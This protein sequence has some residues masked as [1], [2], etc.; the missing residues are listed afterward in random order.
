MLMLQT[1]RDKEFFQQSSRIT[2]QLRV[3]GRDGRAR[4]TAVE[5]FRPG[6]FSFVLA[7]EIDIVDDSHSIGIERLSDED[8]EF[9]LV[10]AGD[11]PIVDLADH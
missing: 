1:L 8:R 10:S 2:L 6:E 5:F 3:R 7:V 9:L 11:R 4:R